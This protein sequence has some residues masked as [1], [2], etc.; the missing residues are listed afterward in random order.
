MAKDDNYKIG[1]AFHYALRMEAA[2][3]MLKRLNNPDP[4]LDPLKDLDLKEKEKTY[5]YLYAELANAERDQENF[6]IA[7]KLGKQED[8]Y[9]KYSQQQLTQDVQSQGHRHGGGSILVQKP[10]QFQHNPWFVQECKTCDPSPSRVHGFDSSGSS[11]DPPRNLGDF[12]LDPLP[13]WSEYDCEHGKHPFACNRGCIF[14]D[15]FK[16]IPSSKKLSD[17]SFHQRK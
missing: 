4:D 9:H 13:P 6:K 16:R 10:P 7:E 11:N 12:Q 15:D 17:S 8:I 2:K 14:P 1:K 5:L 3:A